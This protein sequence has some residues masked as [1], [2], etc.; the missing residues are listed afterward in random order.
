M[1]KHCIIL[2]LI[3]LMYQSTLTAQK[4]VRKG[5]RPVRVKPATAAPVYT[6][7]QLTG[8]WQEYNRKMESSKEQVSFTDS[9]MLDFYK[10]N[11]VLV[12]DGISISQKGVAFID[13]TATLLLAGDQYTILMLD[14]NSLVIN[15][16]EFIRSL[17]KTKKFYSE[18][19]GFLKSDMESFEKP[20]AVNSNNLMG[21]WDIY[22]RQANPGLK[23]SVLI[24][25][26]TF[27]SAAKDAL[28]GNIS[29]YSSTKTQTASFT[30]HISGTDMH[31]NAGNMHWI[32]STYKASANELVFGRG[33]EI[34]YY[35]KKNLTPSP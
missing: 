5:V 34:V 9:L 21:R 26:M 20:A 7:N 1:F 4:V 33:K 3:S 11:A 8:K 24:K 6:I 2:L 35:A 16:G 19:L 32:W 14:K 12:K 30:G 29:F 27:T 25:S 18:T 10:R 28:A 23:D 15:D 31:I 17:K 13:G 22:R